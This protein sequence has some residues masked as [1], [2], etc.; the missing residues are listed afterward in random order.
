[1]YELYKSGLEALHSMRKSQGL[2]LEKAADISA[3]MKDLLEEGDEISAA[4]GEGL[5]A[6]GNS[7][8]L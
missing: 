5:C 1:M 6:V 7:S 2:T 3:E 4:L 8:A